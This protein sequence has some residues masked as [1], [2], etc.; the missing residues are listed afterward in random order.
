MDSLKGHFL[1]ASPHLVDP[2]FVRTVVLLVEH[3]ENGAFGVV[4]NRPSERSVQEIWDEVAE[5]PCDC[6]EPIN[7]GGPVLGPLLALHT[8][9]MYSETEVVPGVFV[10]TQRD[11]LDHIVR[12]DEPFRVFSGY[13][14]WGA[15]QLEAELK[16]GGWITMAADRRYVFA[17]ADDLWHQASQAIARDV[18]IST[19]KIRHVPED[20]SLN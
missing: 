16:Q 11:H 19:L 18:L 3:N 5:V 15:G 13:S 6:L 14:G 20:P 4:L 9:P 7:V 1:I 17:P 10:A 2:N 12:Q 8:Q